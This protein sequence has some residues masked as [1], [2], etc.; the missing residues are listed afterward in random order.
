MFY[1]YILKSVVDGTL[2]AGNTEN[3]ER[4]LQEHN[5]GKMK[6][7]KRKMPWILVYKELFST[8]TDAM[9]REKFFKSGRGRKFLNEVLGN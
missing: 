5:R 4:R 7:T 6:Y 1:T 2:Y 8:R 9:K 3:I